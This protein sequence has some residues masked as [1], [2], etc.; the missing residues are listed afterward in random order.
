M[1]ESR[2]AGLSSVSCNTSRGRHSRGIV[3]RLLLWLVAYPLAIVLVWVA[4]HWSLRVSAEEPLRR[5][6]VQ[7]S[8]GVHQ[9][10]GELVR[11]ELADYFRQKKG[12]EPG[13]LITRKDV[14]AV[15]KR[16][17]SRGYQPRDAKQI[18]EASLSESDF[19]VQLLGGTRGRKFMRKVKK[20]SL[21]YDRLDRIAQVPQGKR[22]LSD[23]IKLP[24]A[25]RYAPVR[26]A[27]GIPTLLDLLPKRRSSRTRSI[28]DYDK[29]TGKIYT[30]KQLQE[31]L[32]AKPKS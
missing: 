10:G 14:E 7:V 6:S 28:K 22:T 26:P 18:I 19:L 23:L 5:G 21:I 12:Y 20:E 8:R 4:I 1:S 16:L 24:D 27:R 30:A 9:G 2:V 3:Y 17:A 13:D 32:E 11:R 15:L 25:H 29:P 31:R